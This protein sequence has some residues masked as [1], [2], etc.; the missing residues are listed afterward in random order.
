MS[1]V[2][3][4]L[5]RISLA[6]LQSYMLS[7]KID[8]GTGR[9][10]IKDSKI[11][12]EIIKEENSRFILNGNLII[13]S[14]LYGITPVRIILRKNAKLIINGDFMIGNGVRIFLHKG[15]ELTIGGKFNESMS[16][17]TSDS[18]IMV[19][20]YI[21]IGKDFL[22]AWNVFITDSDWH[23]IDGVQHQKDV[24]IGNKVWLANNVNILKGTVLGD[25]CIVASNSKVINK[26][27]E[28]SVL[29]AGEKGEIIKRNVNW[30]RDI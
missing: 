1:L 11:K 20:K 16:G 10:I 29:I 8:E 9:I 12:V 2:K 18:L 28:Q 25:G 7:K 26:T 23:H 17:I 27:F 5:N 24:K 15:S 3:R 22:C 6:R 13:N 21:N 19:N 30:S 14:H 4:F